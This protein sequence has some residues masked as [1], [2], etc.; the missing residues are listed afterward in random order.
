MVSSRT[1][2]EERADSEVWRLDGGSM[3]E[4]GPDRSSIVYNRRACHGVSYIAL[5]TELAASNNSALLFPHLAKSQ[6]GQ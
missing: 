5:V 3:G 6:S 1:G 2:R 4:F